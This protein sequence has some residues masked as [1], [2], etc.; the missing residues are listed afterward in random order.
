[1]E[2]KTNVMRM[3]DQKKIPYKHHNYTETGAISGEDVAAALNQD[4]ATVFKTLVTVGKT[5]NYYVFLVPVL[6][7]LDL[8]KSSKGRR[9]KEGRN[10]QVKRTSPFN[11]L[12]SRRL[13]AYRYEE[14][15]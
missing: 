14:K 8:K 11:R 9:G 7:E 1:M 15:F 12:R 6:G 5:G 13:F 2:D 10:D 4:P 3:L